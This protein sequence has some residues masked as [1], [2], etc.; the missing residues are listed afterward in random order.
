MI[1]GQEN[2]KML[3][4]KEKKQQQRPQTNEQ[5]RVREDGLVSVL[6]SSMEAGVISASQGD[7]GHAFFLPSGC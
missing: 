5:N 3:D 1:L 6:H 2:T 4:E 7:T